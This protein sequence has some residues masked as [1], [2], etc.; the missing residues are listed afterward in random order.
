MPWSMTD[1][2]DRRCEEWTMNEVVLND[3]LKEETKL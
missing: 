3:S 1:G 2:N